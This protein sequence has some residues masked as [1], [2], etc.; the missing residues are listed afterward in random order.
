M[1]VPEPAH[2]C[3]HHHIWKSQKTGAAAVA[4]LTRM[5]KINNSFGPFPFLAFQCMQSTETSHDTSTVTCKDD[6]DLR[7]PKNKKNL[8]KPVTDGWHVVGMICDLKHWSP[9]WIQQKSEE[10]KVN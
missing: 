8:A 9:P 7:R 2:I 3:I 6:S 5:E 10:R 1:Y 4:L